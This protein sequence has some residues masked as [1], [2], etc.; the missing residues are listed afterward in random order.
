MLRQILYN[1]LT[2][3]AKFTERGTVTLRMAQDMHFLRLQVVDTGI[4]MNSEQSMRI[5]QEFTQAD[6]SITRKF[7]GTGLGLALCRKFTGLLGG[8]LTVQSAPGLGSTFTVLLPLH[9]S[10]P[11]P[12]GAPAS[13]SE[14]GVL[15]I[16]DDPDMRE[17]LER[18]LVKAGVAVATA[19]GGEEG[20]RLAAELRPR[21]IT[22][23]VAMPD[24]DGWEVLGRLKADP[25]L[26]DI[27]VVLITMLEGR[28]KG[29][30]LG[31]ADFLSKPL[32]RDDLLSALRRLQD[33]GAEGRDLLLVEDDLPI[34][35]ALARILEGEGWRVR[36]A[37]DGLEALNQLRHRIPRIV[38][39]DLMM[40]CLDGF[41]VVAA[42]QDNGDWREVPIIV[43][44]AKELT[45]EDLR[46][47][48]GPHVFKVFRKGA[49]TR[50][51]LVEA[52]RELAKRWE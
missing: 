41:Q 46:R 5:F 9:V 18:M 25:A 12:A 35:E 49:S 27:P 42:M 48:K 6:E 11:L 31:A 22:L 40:P 21:I 44:T 20:L 50:V 3:A 15:V 16:D 13:D 36:T 32:T 37:P 24:M 43:L 2:N 7:G 39:L 19:G 8:E 29:F 52:V 45:D 30:A 51:E 38:I 33:A 1:L 34:Q 26:R 14:C 10:P 28:E 47:L 17:A 23:D 4:G